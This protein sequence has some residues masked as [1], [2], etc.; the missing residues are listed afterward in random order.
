MKA[1]L[2]ELREINKQLQNIRNILEPKK[3]VPEDS[4]G[5]YNSGQQKCKCGK[6]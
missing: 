3:F 1:V 2:M 6:N 4:H 5:T